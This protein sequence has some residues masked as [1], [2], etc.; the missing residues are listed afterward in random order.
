VLLG[1]HGVLAFAASPQ[2]AAALV[3]VL[4]EAAQAELAAE[5]LGGAQDF[6]PG[7]LDEVRRAMARVR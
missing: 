3:T 5:D 6:P 2:A 4:E 1:N 7:A